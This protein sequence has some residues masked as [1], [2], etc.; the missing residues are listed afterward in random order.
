LAGV[1]PLSA[2]N[3][4]AIVIVL[5]V[6]ELALKVARIPEER[7]VEVFAPNSPD[8]SFNEG[9][10]HRGMRHGFDFLD[11]EGPKVGEPPVA[12]RL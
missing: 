6:F 1:A 10:R 9:M 8:Q 11:L 5:E 12:V 3:T 4:N 2:V 7:V